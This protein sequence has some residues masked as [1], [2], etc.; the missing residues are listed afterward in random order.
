MADS[1]RARAVRILDAALQEGRLSTLEWDERTRAV[2]AA[3][4]RGDLSRVTS[5]LPEASAAEPAPPAGVAH[6]WSIGVLSAFNRVGRWVVP[7]RHTVIVA[8]GGG[9]L[10]LADAVF[11]EEET[12]IRLVVLFGGIR[13]VVP[14]NSTVRVSVRNVI[15]GG[16]D[17]A[18][19]ER[20]KPVVRVTG[21][22]MFGGF[23]IVRRGRGSD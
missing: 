14:E 10:D 23:G 5:D 1:D 11:A 13:V 4:T 3:S 17:M 20:G 9:R 22:S 16:G 21:V 19:A 7:A 15:G 12:E 2:Y 18:S 6:R 8:C